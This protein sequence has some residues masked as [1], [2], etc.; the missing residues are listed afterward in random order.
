[1]FIYI[2]KNQI[3]Y[4]W[5]KEILIKTINLRHLFPAEDCVQYRY[6]NFLSTNTGERVSVVEQCEPLQ[7]KPSW[8]TNSTK[9][10]SLLLKKAQPTTSK[11]IFKN[12]FAN[13]VLLSSQCGSA[14][15]S[16][17]NIFFSYA[18]EWG[19]IW[20]KLLSKSDHLHCSFVLRS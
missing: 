18:H 15:E 19:Y 4:N 8:N 7:L 20:Q 2:H 13:K 17:W 12:S 16:V 9:T 14:V 10:H 5:D 6:I 3:K 1:M 11:L